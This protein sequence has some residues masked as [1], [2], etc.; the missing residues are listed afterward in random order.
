MSEDEEDDG[1]L[2]NKSAFFKRRRF[3]MLNDSLKG[4]L[5]RTNE[6]GFLELVWASGILQS[7]DPEPAKAY[8][9]NYPPEAVTREFASPWA[10]FAWDM[11]TL[12]NMILTTPRKPPRQVGKN[13][14]LDTTSF[15]AMHATVVKLRKLE[16]AEFLLI[17]DEKLDGRQE[18]A[19][20]GQR[21]FPAQQ[22]AF[23]PEVLFRFL[24]VYN[25]PAASAMFA[26][27]NG[28]TINEFTFQAAQLFFLFLRNSRIRL[29]SFLQ[30]QD[31]ST[32]RQRTLDLLSLPLDQAR[33]E[34]RKLFQNAKASAHGLRRVAYQ[35]SLLRKY[36]LIF[37]R[38]TNSYLAP[39]PALIVSRMTSGLYY[40]LV[41]NQAVMARSAQLF[42]EYSRRLIEAYFPELKATAQLKYGK[43][44]MEQSETPDILVSDDNRLSMVIECKSTKQT[45]AAQFSE[46]P[47]GAAAKAIPQLAKAIL[48]LWRF[49]A[50]CRSGEFS[51]YELQPSARAIVLTL[52][53]W[54][55]L[56]YSFK[57]EAR[58]L[59]IAQAN[60][61]GIPSDIQNQPITFI[62]SKGL[63]DLLAETDLASMYAI[64]DT[65]AS[66]PQYEGYAP[67]DLGRELGLL[68]PR[69]RFPLDMLEVIPWLDTIRTR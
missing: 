60:S 11:E 6:I 31:K 15:F 42:E 26:A 17:A 8:L 12:I 2:L 67:R 33:V 10:V 22:G 40:D 36:P 34:A 62:S 68:K 50:A 66:D 21:Q 39:I 4:D 25:H 43:N 44:K 23:H 53:D 13:Y 30:E 48:Q 24:S 52:D 58:R 45:F 28:I 1:S 41:G 69:T 20:I 47:I 49:F 64:L 9:R 54:F 18:M 35:P 51:Q 14:F 63:A 3:Y 57:R 7:S 37:D 59:A 65:A 38:A 29:P 61:E 19:R 32:P 16:D 27:K 56:D 46:D 5:V 55:L